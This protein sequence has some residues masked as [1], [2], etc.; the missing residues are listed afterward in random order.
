MALLGLHR[1]A[2]LLLAN[3]ALVDEDLGDLIDTGASPPTFRGLGIRTLLPEFYLPT[4]YVVAHLSVLLKRS[5]MD[6]ISPGTLPIIEEYGRSREIRQYAIWTFRV[7][8]VAPF[9]DRAW[10][11]LSISALSGFASACQHA[12]ASGYRLSA[13]QLVIRITYDNTRGIQRRARALPLPLPLPPTLAPTISIRHSRASGNPLRQVLRPS[14][15][16]PS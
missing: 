1:Q 13:F 14:I 15:Q 12:L 4:C 9:S 5:A 11:H 3:L 10:Q 6:R 7:G 16:N 2:H 8:Q